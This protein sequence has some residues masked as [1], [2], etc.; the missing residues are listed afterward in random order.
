MLCGLAY[1]VDGVE[2]EGEQVGVVVWSFPLQDTHQSLHSHA[3]IH[4][5]LG[6]QP[7]TVVW[8]PDKTHTHTHP[9]RPV[10]PADCFSANGFLGALNWFSMYQILV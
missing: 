7:Q 3:S 5:E 6:Q 4:T 10:Q 2:Q 1:L 9:I 8:L